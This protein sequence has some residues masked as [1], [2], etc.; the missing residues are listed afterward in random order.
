MTNSYW[1]CTIYGIAQINIICFDQMPQNWSSRIELAF[2]YIC[3]DVSMLMKRIQICLFW[4]CINQNLC[5]TNMFISNEY[6]QNRMSKN[7]I[8]AVVLNF[9]M[10]FPFYLRAIANKMILAEAQ[11]AHVITG[12]NLINVMMFGACIWMH[13]RWQM[14]HCA[15]I[16]R[17]WRRICLANRIKLQVIDVI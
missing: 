7:A 10:K 13:H 15:H 9:S 1:Y 16:L 5:V 12:R 17:W 8:I 6:T 2:I 3:A 4:H 11:M 14:I